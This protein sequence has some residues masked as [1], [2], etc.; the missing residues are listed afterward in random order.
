MKASSLTLGI[1]A[2]VL[3]GVVWVQQRALNSLTHEFDGLRRTNLR[4]VREADELRRQQAASTRDAVRR[5]AS[6]AASSPEGV[7]SSVPSHRPPAPATRAEEMRRLLAA[8]NSRETALAFLARLTEND[9]VY[10]MKSEDRPKFRI[11]RDDELSDDERARA[12]G[13][14]EGASGG[15]ILF[16]RVEGRE[17]VH[18]L[19]SGG[20]ERDSL[21][22]GVLAYLTESDLQKFQDEMLFLQ[23]E[24]AVLRASRVL[25]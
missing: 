11:L 13:V 4:L 6:Q 22:P 9:P 1:F 23:A 20:F 17:G 19:N 24:A 18:I 21:P 3:G 10:Q 16:L 8:V 2:I 7:P 14:R 25:K 15:R 5:P 12:A